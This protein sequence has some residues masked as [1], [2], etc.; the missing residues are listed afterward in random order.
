MSATETVR[1]ASV[2]DEPRLF[3]TCCPPVGAEVPAAYHSADGPLS[4]GP[5]LRSDR[6]FNG[7]ASSVC[8]G[9]TVWPFHASGSCGA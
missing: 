3:T 2:Y 1:P 5:D 8:A 7:A 6:T 4:T 9:T